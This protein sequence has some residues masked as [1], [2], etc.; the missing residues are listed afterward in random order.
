[1]TSKDLQR[2][3]SGIFI[4]CWDVLYFERLRVERVVG[5]VGYGMSMADHDVPNA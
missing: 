5:H 1:M 4:I 3:A 2:I